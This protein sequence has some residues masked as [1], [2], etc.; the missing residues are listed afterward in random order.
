MGQLIW[1]EFGFGP[2]P[3]YLALAWI[4]WT[5]PDYLGEMPDYLTPF[6]I[7]PKVQ[8]IWPSAQIIWPSAQ[9]IWPSPIWPSAQIIWPAQLIWLLSFDFWPW[10]YSVAGE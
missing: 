10:P 6:W 7:W 8:I 2:S 3:D 4:I 9:I 5:W 1:P